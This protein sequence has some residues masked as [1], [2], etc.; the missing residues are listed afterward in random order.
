MRYSASVKEYVEDGRRY[1]KLNGSVCEIHSDID[2][3]RFIV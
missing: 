3:G 1:I 2:R